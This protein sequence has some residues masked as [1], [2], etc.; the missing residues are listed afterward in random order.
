[1]TRT[2]AAVGLMLILA[3][4]GSGKSID[5]DAVR[6]LYPNATKAQMAKLIDAVRDGCHSNDTQFGLEVATLQD[7]GA[8]ATLNALR[9]GCPDKVAKALNG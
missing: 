6:A 8:T 2:L 3:A 7:R 4:C 9:A 1:M 5:T